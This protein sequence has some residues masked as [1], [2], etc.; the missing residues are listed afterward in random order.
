MLENRVFLLDDSIWKFFKHIYQSPLGDLFDV[1]NPTGKVQKE[2]FIKP[3]IDEFKRDGKL[4][5]R[6]ERIFSFSKKGP[7]TLRIFSK[8]Y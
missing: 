6:L 3:E 4:S 1:E 2:V 7:L 8:I 5:V